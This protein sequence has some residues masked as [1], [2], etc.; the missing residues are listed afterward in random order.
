MCSGWEISTE[1]Q[2]DRKLGT[3]TFLIT[4][5]LYSGHLIW[6]SSRVV[7]HPSWIF[8]NLNFLKLST[9]VRGLSF[10]ATAA[11]VTFFRNTE[12]AKSDFRSL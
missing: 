10:N 1:M 11:I 2:I 3:L 4:E 12:A 5:L 7:N 8:S 9:K 6:N